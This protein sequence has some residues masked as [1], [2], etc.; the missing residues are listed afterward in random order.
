MVL[1]LRLRTE[2]LRLGRLPLEVLGRAVLLGLAVLWLFTLVAVRGLEELVLG[3][4]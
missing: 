1:S 2:L 4:G 3:L